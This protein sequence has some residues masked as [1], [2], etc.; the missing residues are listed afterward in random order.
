M[1]PQRLTKVPALFSIVIFVMPLPSG[2]FPGPG[3]EAARGA[4]DGRSLRNIGARERTG[5][6][7]GMNQ[8]TEEFGGGALIQN[9][10][11]T[12]LYQRRR[13][14]PDVTTSLLGNCGKEGRACRVREDRYHAVGPSPWVA[15][16]HGS[17]GLRQP[18]ECTTS[19]QSR[20]TEVE[21]LAR[22][23]RV[24]HPRHNLGH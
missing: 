21:K 22:N 24:P 6:F 8:Q 3:A 18:M 13:R 20:R 4:A 15:R 19:F 1:P 9:A 16:A 2:P 14:S 10:D 17:R 12:Q 5:L 23:R 7:G 11:I